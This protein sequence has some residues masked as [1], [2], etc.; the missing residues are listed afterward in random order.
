M[1][2]ELREKRIRDALS[3]PI[4]YR[5]AADARICRFVL[6]SG[7]FSS[8]R[9]VLCYAG[10][11]RE[12]D[13]SPILRGALD[14]GKRLCLPLCTGNGVMEARCVTSLS[15]LSTGRFGIL[16]PKETSPLVLPAELDLV[17]VPGCTGNER[18][19]RLGYG[20]GYYDRYLPK[21][22]CPSLLLC[23]SRLLTDPIPMDAHDVWMDY[24][25]TE[26]GITACKGKE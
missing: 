5:T 12:V 6:E 14:A 24:L 15:D 11:A 4:E 18:G 25:A 3:L 23:R 20:G 10:T 16:T 13:T 9:T 22:H 8:A 1:K 26:K 19:Q 7:L 17:I 21:T 2:R